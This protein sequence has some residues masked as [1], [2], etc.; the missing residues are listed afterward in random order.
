[1]GLDQK[2]TTLRG[3]HSDRLHDNTAG[4]M[5]DAVSQQLAGALSVPPAPKEGFNDPESYQQHVLQINQRYARE[6]EEFRQ[7]DD[8]FRLR[9]PENPEKLR[10]HILVECADGRN[11]IMLYIPEEKQ[12]SRFDYEWLPSAGTILAP[13]VISVNSRDQVEDFLIQKPHLRKSIFER[14]DLLFGQ[15]IKECLEDNKNEKLSTIHIEFQSHFD[16]EHHPGH[17]CGAHG[18]N[19][20]MAQLET[21]K[22]CMVAELWLKERYPEEYEK[23][24]FKVYRTTHDTKQEGPIVSAA[25]IDRKYL[26]ERLVGAEKLLDFAAENYEAPAMADKGHGIVR[27]FKGNPTEIE[28][29]EHDEQTIRVSNTHFASTLM[30]QSVL[31]IC[32]TNNASTLFDHIKILLGII[33]KNFR[34]RNPFKPSILHL[35]ML[36]GDPTIGEVFKQ[37]NREIAE[38]MELSRRVSEGSLIICRSETDRA[39]F[40]TDVLEAA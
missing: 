23:K 20:I 27:N 17:G 15:K 26:K 28:T 9:D 33:E 13:E 24:L 14:F 35:D 37:L 5:R 30:G 21:I 29:A 12:L 32:W 8:K 25:V 40:K 34:K 1:M 36:K 2:E 38:D 6:H 16:S 10:G 4:E 3:H 18:S 31:E 7:S 22:N 39:T 11:S 19:L